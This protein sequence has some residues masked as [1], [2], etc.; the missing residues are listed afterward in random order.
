MK[1]RDFQ[2]RMSITK[3]LENGGTVTKV[4]KD[5]DRIE[6]RLKRTED[7]VPQP[8]KVHYMTTFAG[9]I[10]YLDKDRY[11]HREDGPAHIYDDGD[12]QYWIHG[13]RQKHL[14]QKD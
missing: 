8:D 6:V 5:Y 3:K 7:G 13:D 14:E 10:I 12:R 2:Q 1:I 9:D 4:L 11:L